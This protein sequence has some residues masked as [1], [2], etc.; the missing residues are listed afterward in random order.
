MKRS[1]SV[2]HIIIAKCEVDEVGDV[3]VDS[4]TRPADARRATAFIWR[5]TRGSG[6]TTRSAAVLA[7]LLVELRPWAGAEDAGESERK[8]VRSEN[9]M[10]SRGRE[11]EGGIRT[12]ARTHGA[13]GA[14]GGGVKMADGARECDGPA[15]LESVIPRRGLGHRTRQARRTRRDQ[16]GGGRCSAGRVGQTHDASA[17][18]CRRDRKPTGFTGAGE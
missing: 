6:S 17:S 14:R 9:N 16:P 15:A 11:D 12:R 5:R 8:W 13:Q 3:V 10:A 2:T 4:T 7:A 18:C 1:A